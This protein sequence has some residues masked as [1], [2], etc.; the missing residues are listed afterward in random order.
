MYPKYLT[1][2]EE[3]GGRVSLFEA[4]CRVERTIANAQE[5]K[6]YQLLRS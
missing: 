1:H 4:F 5:L 6:A 3:G 2:V